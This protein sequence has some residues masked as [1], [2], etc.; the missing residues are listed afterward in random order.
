MIAYVRSLGQ[1]TILD[2]HPVIPYVVPAPKSMVIGDVT[3]IEWALS[4]SEDSIYADS[5]KSFGG[6]EALTSH[7]VKARAGREVKD[8]EKRE[9]ESFSAAGMSFEDVLLELCRP[10]L[11]TKDRK[12][13]AKGFKFGACADCSLHVIMS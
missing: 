3:W 4:R 5:A 12:N 11:A 1:R 10:S 13:A 9:Y 2:P 8:A 6:S 7:L